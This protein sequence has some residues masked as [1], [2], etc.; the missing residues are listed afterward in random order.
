M[1]S[2]NS[3]KKEFESASASKEIGKT[4]NLAPG[5]ERKEAMIRMVVTKHFPSFCSSSRINLAPGLEL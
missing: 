2:A 3:H 4:P 5:K 1:L